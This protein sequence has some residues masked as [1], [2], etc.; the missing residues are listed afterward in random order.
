MK[1]ATPKIVGSAKTYVT[2]HLPD[3]QQTALR[4]AIN[5][6]LA[7]TN[8]INKLVDGKYVANMDIP[9]D[10]REKLKEAHYALA[11]SNE[12]EIEYDITE[13][14]EKINYRILKN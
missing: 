11:W 1:K 5:L 14:G 10:V 4:M 3:N 8:N 6:S 9:P 7:G 12:I 2:I 13:F